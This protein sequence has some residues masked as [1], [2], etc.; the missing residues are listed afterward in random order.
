MPFPDPRSHRIRLDDLRQPAVRNRR[1]AVWN[2]PISLDP[3]RANARVTQAVSDDLAKVARSL[4]LTPPLPFTR[5]L[6]NN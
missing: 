6:G 4:S 5:D 2:D 3:A 1:R